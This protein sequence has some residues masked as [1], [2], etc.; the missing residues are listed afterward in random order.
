MPCMEHLIESEPCEE[1]KKPRK[2]KGWRRNTKVERTRKH[3]QPRKNNMTQ[4]TK[5]VATLDDGTTQELDL[6][7]APAPTTV[8]VVVT[9]EV[10]AGGTPTATVTSVA[11]KA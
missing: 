9:I 4:I 5:I 7:Q 11:N 10:G 1:T 8:P 3:Y 2:A 6:T